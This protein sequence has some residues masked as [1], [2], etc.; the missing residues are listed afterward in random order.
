MQEI[1]TVVVM[2]VEILE[3][4]SAAGGAGNNGNM[5]KSEREGNRKGRKGNLKGDQRREGPGYFVWCMFCGN[6]K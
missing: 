1:T 4:R 6:R 2:A 5:K 3:N